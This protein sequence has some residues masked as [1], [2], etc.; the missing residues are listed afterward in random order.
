VTEKVR[1]MNARGLC[2]A[3]R[4]CSKP[5]DFGRFHA[6]GP[7]VA[8]TLTQGTRHRYRDRTMLKTEQS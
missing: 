4:R 5:V 6:P 3:H 2:E 7:A 1:E 8:T